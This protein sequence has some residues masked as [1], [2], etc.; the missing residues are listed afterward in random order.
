[1]VENREIVG[2]NDQRKEEDEEEKS[3]SVRRLFSLPETD[4]RHPGPVTR[5]S[6][7]KISSFQ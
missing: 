5:E 1:V 7:C 2:Q 6:P 4:S 3:G